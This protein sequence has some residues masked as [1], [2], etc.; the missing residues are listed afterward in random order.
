M[1]NSQ[2][3][4]QGNNKSDMALINAESCTSCNASHSQSKSFFNIFYFKNLKTYHLNKNFI[5]L[6]KKL[7]SFH[8]NDL[9]IRVLYENKQGKMFESNFTF[10]QNKREDNFTC[11]KLPNLVISAK[12]VGGKKPTDSE[13]C[14]SV[15]KIKVYEQK[16]S[17]KSRNKFSKLA[18]I[19]MHLEADSYQK[20]AEWKDNTHCAC[21]L[22]GRYKQDI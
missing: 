5:N 10:D 18:K 15:V 20:A 22:I 17:D 16:S 7:A 11:E 14:D 4:T 12:R 8:R 1:N 3:L 6:K 2:S 19:D 13:T 21:V 9:T